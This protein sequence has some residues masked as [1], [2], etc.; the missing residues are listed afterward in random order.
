MQHQEFLKAMEQ[1]MIQRQAML[2]NAKKGPEANA[3]S[4]P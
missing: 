1:Q 3:Q 2:E 4:N